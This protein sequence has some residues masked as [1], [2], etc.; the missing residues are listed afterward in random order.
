MRSNFF[1]EDK[2]LYV[3]V[4]RLNQNCTIQPGR[5]SPF[6]FPAGTYLYVG[7]A[8]KDLLPRLQRHFR[9]EKKFY[10]HIDYLLQKA[11]VEKAW[12]KPED[13]D[14]CGTVTRIKEHTS[15]ASQPVIKFGSSDC[16][17]HSH[18]FYL[19]PSSNLE[20]LRKYLGFQKGFYGN[21]I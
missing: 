9:R 13:L 16:R 21:Q 7:R 6:R 4:I 3:L 20:G 10:W 14:E 2:G 17:C 8:Q 15:D 19:S 12:V 18:L 5:L 1:K 11:E